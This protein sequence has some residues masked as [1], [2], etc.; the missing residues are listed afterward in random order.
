MRLGP[1]GACFCASDHFARWLASQNLTLSDVDTTSV[2]R[3]REAMGRCAK[4]SLPHR[5]RGL[6]LALEFLLQKGIASIPASPVPDTPA[7]IWLDRFGDYLERVAGTAPST[8]ESYRTIVERFLQNRFSDVEPDWSALSAADLSAVIQ[9]E[10][11][12]RRGFGR[13]VPSV[14]LRSFLRC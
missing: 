2:T 5:G 3:Y 11:G 7:E 9:H 8:R 6:H 1:S 10:A 14:A 13:Q 4:G 12:K